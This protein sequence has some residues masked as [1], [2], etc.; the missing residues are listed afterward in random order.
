MSRFREYAAIYPEAAFV[1]VGDN[2]QGDVLAAEILWTQMREGVGPSRLLGCL[3]LKVVPLKATCSML[4]RSASQLGMQWLSL[5]L[6]PSLEAHI[7]A[8]PSCV[9]GG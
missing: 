1:L 8:D 5:S 3:L 9:L 4:L 6:P 7:E 2:G